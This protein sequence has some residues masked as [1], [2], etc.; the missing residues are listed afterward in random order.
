MTS[1]NLV[2]DFNNQMSLLSQD[3]GIK[4]SK[5]SNL[6]NTQIVDNESLLNCMQFDSLLQMTD[7]FTSKNQK[8]MHFTQRLEEMM[9]TCSKN[10]A[11][12]ELINPASPVN[13]KQG[14][15]QPLSD[16]SQKVFSIC[17]EGKSKNNAQHLRYLY[18]RIRNSFNSYILFLINRILKLSSMKVL[19][20]NLKIVNQ[21]NFQPFKNVFE[22]CIAQLLTKRLSFEVLLKIQSTELESLNS[23]LKK[24]IKYLYREYL[25]STHYIKDM[26]L[27]ESQVGT[28]NVKLLIND[29]KKQ[30]SCFKIN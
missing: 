17:K 25:S 15:S 9:K 21:D 6:Y 7:Y 23:L 20:H 16:N 27:M 22:N 13:D 8:Y 2:L 5:L 18:K 12:G 28:K 19:P 24:P 29:L 30:L 4:L 26:K 10:Q 3:L 1:P 11:T 14:C